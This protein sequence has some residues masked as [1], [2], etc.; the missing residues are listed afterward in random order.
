M[1]D[2]LR[3]AAEGPTLWTVTTPN[4]EQELHRDDARLKD[5]GGKEIADYDR[6]G[7]SSLQMNLTVV[8]STFNST[9]TQEVRTLC[10]SKCTILLNCC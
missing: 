9:T 7:A 1:K 2:L 6:E 4:G 3:G 5:S 8:N 10:N